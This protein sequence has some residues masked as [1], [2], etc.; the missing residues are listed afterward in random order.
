MK[1]YVYDHCPF[2]VKS[3]SIFGLKS[4]PFVLVVMMNDD[5]ATP[6]RMIGRKVAPIL[7]DEGHF[8]PESMDIVKKIDGLDGGSVLTGDTN[9]MVADWI[10]QNT[11]TLYAL[12]MPRWASAPLP[13]F[14]TPEARAYFTKN[15]E[16]IIGPFSN[17]LAESAR[18]IDA[19]NLDLTS[20]APLI[21]SPSAINGE[22]STDDIH[23]F[24]HLR[25][26]SIVSGVRYPQVVDDYRQIMSEKTGVQLHD[27]IAT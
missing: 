10:K 11:A 19:V 24:A 25:S 15:K 14:A 22:L 4:Q 17:R 3:R 20:L 18:L 8:L 5:A 27:A 6:E 16:A 26:L 1:L 23:L 12:A 9:P 21:E 2:C 7:E 13:E